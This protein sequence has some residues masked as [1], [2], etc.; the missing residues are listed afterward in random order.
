MILSI[1]RNLY[2]SQGSENLLNCF[3]ISELSDYEDYLILRQPLKDKNTMNDQIL[4]KLPAY[5]KSQLSS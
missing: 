1:F 4:P 5:Y 3:N 2:L